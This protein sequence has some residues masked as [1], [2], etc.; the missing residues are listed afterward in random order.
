M[1]GLLAQVSKLLLA[2]SPTNPQPIFHFFA[3]CVALKSR[4]RFEWHKE[5]KKLYVVD[6]A[7][8]ERTKRVTANVMAFAIENEGMAYN[9][10]LCWCRGFLACEEGRSHNDQGQIVLLGEHR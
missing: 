7:L 4:F 2:G 9:H 5:T 8:G 1:A 10:A 6:I 3:P